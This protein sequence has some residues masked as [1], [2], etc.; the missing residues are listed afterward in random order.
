[1][2][3]GGNPGG[4]RLGQDVNFWGH[5]W[6]NQVTGGDYTSNV[7]FKGFA[8]P[9]NQIHV[10]EVSAGSGGPLDD[11]CW[12]SKPG[13]SFPPPLTLPA[14][15]EVIISTAISGDSTG[16]IFGN[17]AAAAVCQVDP[18]PPYGPDPGKPGFC[19]L[20]AVIEDAGV[21]PAKPGL[22]ATQEQ[23][24]TVLPN[25][26]FN[27]KTVI[28]NNS[29]GVADAIV[30]NENFDGVTPVTGEDTFASLVNGEQV[31]A[32]FP[33]TT[34][35]VPVRQA[36]ETSLAYQQRLA[37]L[38]RLFTSTGSISFTDQFNEPFVP[39]GVTSFSRLQLPRL[40]LA[41]S[42]PSCVGPGS[43]IPYKV[44]VTNIG[45]ADAES[46]SL[47]MSMPD[48]SSPT[49]LIPTIAVGTAATSTINFVVPAIL[50]KQ[51]NETDQQYI[52]RL[53]SIDGSLLTALATANWQDTIGNNY[54]AIDQRFISI[55]ERVPIV[56]TTPQGP[57][58]VLPGQTENLN[59]TTQNIGGGNAS[60]VFL[61]ITN[62]D[63]SLFAVAPFALPA[64]QAAVGISSFT[65]PVITA[66]QTGESD[67]AYLTR[68]ASID[69]SGLNFVGQLNWLDA[70]NNNY[71][72]THTAFTSTEVLPVLTAMLTAPATASAGD[73]ITYTITLTNNGHATATLGTLTVA[74]PDGSVQNAVPQQS[75]LASGAS[76]TATVNFTIPISQQ[77][78]T[79]VATAKVT[80]LDANNNNYGPLSP[81]ASTQVA[82]IPPTVLASCLP[83]SSLS[84]LLNPDKTVSSYVPNGAWS[85]GVSG[86]RF[87]PVE[88]EGRTAAIPTPGAVNS[89][90]SNSVTSQTVCTANST[91]VY[92]LSNQ[93]LNTTLKSGSTSFTGFS[94]GSCQNCGVA[95]NPVTNQAVI[96]MGLSGGAGIQF[97]DLNTNTFAPP[98][99]TS[100]GKVSED[101]SVDPG[102]GLVL[103]PSEDAIYGLYK[104]DNTGTHYLSNPISGGGEFDS[105]AEDCTTGIALAPT[106]FTGNIFIA[107]LTQATFN[108][109]T[110]PPSWT[111]PAK[112][113]NFPEFGNLAAGSS[114]IAIAPGSHLGI[115]T[116][117]FGGNAFGVIQLPATSGTGTPTI[118]DYVLA[119]LPAE[120]TGAGFSFGFDPHTVSA[121]VSPSSGKA[122]GLVADGG[123]TFLAAIDL[124]ALM[125][126]HRSGPHTV[127]PAIDLVATGIVRYI[128]TA[129]IL[130]KVTPNSSKQGQQ[131]LIVNI[132]GLATNFVQGT[133]TVSFGAGAG[134]TVT[135]VTVNS[136]TSIA[137]TINIDPIASIGQRN[138]TVTTGTE[139]DVLNGAFSV[140]AGPAALTQLTPNSGQQG[141]QNLSVA[142]TGSATHFA[143]GTTSANFST[144][145]SVQSVTVNS[146]TSATAVVNIDPLTGTGGR[147]VT[148]TTAGE[149]ASGAIFNVTPG[150]AK[151]S[152]VSPNSSPQGQQGL[153]VT[154][155]G[156]STHFTQ[157][158][159][160]ANFGAGISV[161]S[162]TVI[163]PTRA[164]VVI[165]L[166]AAATIGPRDVTLTTSG[167]TATLAGGFAVTAG[168]P[169][170]TAVNPSSGQQ[171][172]QSLSVA[173]SGAFTHFVAGTTTASF[174]AGITVSSLTV[175]S[176][177][178]ATAVINIDPSAAAGARNVTLSTG[179][180]IAALT[181][182]F[183]VTPGTPVLTQVNP[184][185]GAVGQQGLSV[186]VTG[187][188]THFVQGSTSA[189]FGGGVGVVSLTV[190]SPTSF[191]A[192]LN[193]STGATPGPQTVVVSDPSEF[194]TLPNGFTITTQPFLAQV[195][196]NAAQQGTLNLPVALIAQNTHFVQGTTTVSFGAGVTVVSV[197]VNSAS[198]ATAVISI[199]PAATPGT[200]DVTA[201][202]GTEVVTLKG[203]FTV[204]PPPPSVSTNLPEGTVITSPTQII[205][206]VNSGS[207]AL[208]YA[209]A[210]ADGTVTNPVFTTFA[211][212]T[213]A[214]SNG[215]LG[216]LDPTLLLNG[217]YIILLTSTDQF[218]QT[219]QVSSDVN[220]QG[221]AK[222]GNF[223][224][225]FSDLN[226]PVPG[227]P[228]SVLRTYDSRDKASHDFGFGWTLSLANVR[229]QKNGILGANW[230]M[231]SSGGLLPNFCLQ[232]TKPHIVTITF[233]DNTVYKFEASTSPQCQQVAP[234]ET[235]N[236][237]F[238]QIP[239]TTGTPGATLQIVGDNSPLVNPASPGPVDLLSIDTLEDLN[240][241][242]FQLTTIQGFKYVIDQTRGV[243]SVTDPNG[244][245]LTINASGIISSNGKS[246]VFSRDSQGR[247]TRIADPT[248]LAYVYAYSATGD[249]TSFTDPAGNVT[250]FTYDPTHLLI[251]IVDP[252]GIQAIRNT[253]D[254]SGRLTSTTD[255]NGNTIQINTDVAAQQEVIRDRLGNPTILQY[256]SD[257]NVAQPTR[258]GILRSQ[259]LMPM[260]IC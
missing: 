148:V 118:S 111:A 235:T 209:L 142:I 206:S 153:S 52:A 191:T 65:V 227:L 243:T 171:G 230:N 150:P 141:Q 23:P 256:D 165:N 236:V 91:D 51:P 96:A 173:I 167:E 97:L 100:N 217:S 119:F 192:V 121:Y 188:F 201:T 250:T 37:A 120:P 225:T 229:L 6:A 76:T 221:K 60:Q 79:I 41:I 2:V 220:V 196:P 185:T 86:I 55:T 154:V 164:A 62:P 177:T 197:T 110:T 234:P 160:A 13:Q 146:P 61:Q 71:G 176:A 10:C 139:I 34:P 4:L 107:D 145:I 193:I 253:Y 54:G 198:T 74:L 208:K 95:I 88:G 212:G 175:A 182:G 161:V 89:C 36:N 101:I 231:T 184:N 178:S 219:T 149:S 58:T 132:S 64:G 109:G 3:W 222:V 31:T 43:T 14:Y 49:V 247:I 133:T 72:P 202:T 257:G 22:L 81:T 195:N 194:L 11:Q 130:T 50:P 210:S 24:P 56:V 186:V 59:F 5:S 85:R 248:G 151:I 224:L 223:T 18:N 245:T 203:G 239:T 42:G 112:I 103:S 174:G 92:L 124:Q 159:T 215:T 94:G 35:V 32:T 131:N 211:S 104:T 39:M 157:G 200:R 66:K 25:Q 135:S 28:T 187:Q 156:Q 246:V 99:P 9:V 83:T 27:V 213:N 115:V 68:L 45:S 40:T 237:I 181:G 228:I 30:V 38:D 260:T 17:I 190:T 207:W 90:S 170:I 108:T 254:A 255:A 128:A 137:A 15:I 258:W 214:V 57:A 168:V 7:A 179:S 67:A 226:V 147:S 33:V 240:P 123:P 29:S 158:L 125:T 259:P 127:D 16:E 136:S 143:Q 238:T 106:E 205:G 204:L 172:K 183:T 80:W 152:Q 47:V 12:S 155:T 232:E 105:S 98:V 233:P 20:V 48:G 46:V 78:G 93:T 140:T 129:P 53:Q 19:K 249:L 77:A 180:E 21:F 251:N 169:V 162:T 189:S 166:S 63:G 216:T 1:V 114:G 69:N 26:T 134:I 8:D 84:V 117:E 242:V 199:D 75:T 122:F 73:K 113:Q 116:G 241:T 82:G 102:R 70:S 144:G 138:L 252:R 126:A 87:V 163:S 244:N 44:T 218:G